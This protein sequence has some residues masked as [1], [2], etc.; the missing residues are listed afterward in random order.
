[1]CES[2]QTVLTVSRTPVFMAQKIQR[3]NPNRFSQILQ[4]RADRPLIP[5]EI[6]P[7]VLIP[8]QVLHKAVLSRPRRAKGVPKA[9]RAY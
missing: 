6:V 2:R 5:I 3:R 9:Q 1:M 7:L 8:R 4:T